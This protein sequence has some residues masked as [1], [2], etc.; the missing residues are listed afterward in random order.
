MLA[1]CEHE[2]LTVVVDCQRHQLLGHWERW[3]G[4]SVCVLVVK[5]GEGVTSVWGEMGEGEVREK[6]ETRG[7]GGR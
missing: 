4:E 1:K 7:L 2:S 6:V 3:R 5:L